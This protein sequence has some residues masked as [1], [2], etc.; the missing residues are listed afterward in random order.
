MARERH[1]RAAASQ[2]GYSLIELMVVVLVIAVLVAIAIPLFTGFRERT[3]NAG[4]RV[5]LTTGAKTAAGLG[6]DAQGFP[7]VAELA[8]SEPGLD[9]SGGTDESI[10]VIVQDVV[11]ASGDRGDTL[12]YAMSEAGRWYGIRLIQIGADAGRYTCEGADETDVNTMAACG[13]GTA[14]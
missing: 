5:E 14:W 8:L 7:T 1:G 9:F 3:Q 11:P 13:L 10:H 2:R 4:A 6:A 12:L